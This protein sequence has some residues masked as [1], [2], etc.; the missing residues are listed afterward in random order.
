MTFAEPQQG[1][2]RQA[3][4]THLAE[5]YK[6]EPPVEGEYYFSGEVKAFT[7]Q[8]MRDSL[9]LLKANKAV[10]SDLTSRELLV[11]VMAVRGGE[12]RMV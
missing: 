5:V 10:G 2:L 4:H 3:I 7:M 6:R 11:V 12:D 9:T 1:D 8:E